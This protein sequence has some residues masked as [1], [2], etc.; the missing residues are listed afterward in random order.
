MR[1]GFISKGSVSN[2]K[3]NGG[4]KADICIFGFSG[5][6]EVH[7][8]K[9]LTGESNF[10]EE[11]AKLSK[12]GENIV[13]C[14]CVTNSRGH[15]RK[16]A[17]VAENGKLLGVADMLHAVDGEYG[18]GAE[19][20]IFPTKMG[21]MGVLVG[22]DLY[23]YEAVKALALCGSDFIVC[24]FGTVRVEL[25][26]VLL[27]ARAFE[28]GLPV[29]LCG[30]GYSAVATPKGELAFSSPQSPFGVDFV[31]EKEYHLV[32]RRRRGYLSGSGV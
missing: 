8:E 15:R 11:G 28:F 23:F 21:K 16:S 26:S 9:E 17:M 2:Y 25:V 18:S 5:M 1:V 12:Q 22:E 29:F 31:W 13:V 4:E 32:E 30:R 20:R 7:Y 10:F 24:P 14:G 3:Q 6:G 27:R 19:L